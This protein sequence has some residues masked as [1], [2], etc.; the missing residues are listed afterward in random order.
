MKHS[1]CKNVFAMLSQYLDEELPEDVCEDI[2]S[3]ITD[4]PPCVQF[5]ESL[6]KSI[7]LCHS[8]QSM[9]QPSELPEADRRKLYEA[10]QK[11]LAQRNSH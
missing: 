4:C 7:G 3:H 2:E 8:C 5:V 6:K 9:D 10:Y 11:A 1:D